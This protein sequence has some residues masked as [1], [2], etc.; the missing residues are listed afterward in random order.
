ALVGSSCRVGGG[1]TRARTP[2]CRDLGRSGGAVA[3]VY[4]A[5]Q[6]RTQPPDGHGRIAD[7]LVHRVDECVG[8]STAE[9]QQRPLDAWVDVELLSP[10]LKHAIHQR[11]ARE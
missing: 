4:G 11:L 8:R 1:V 2:E 7:G 10:R 3:A 9:L 6:T 5:P